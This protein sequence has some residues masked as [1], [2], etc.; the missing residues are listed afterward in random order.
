MAEVLREYEV[1]VDSQP[2]SIV[3]VGSGDG[4]FV[5]GLIKAFPQVGLTDGTACYNNTHKTFSF[6]ALFLFVSRLFP[7]LV[8]LF[9]SLCSLPETPRDVHFHK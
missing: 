2:C 1:V 7:L 6:I 4:H 5:N 9:F 3:D 8:F